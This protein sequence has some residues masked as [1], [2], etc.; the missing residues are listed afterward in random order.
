M[1][2]RRFLSTL[3]GITAAGF[4]LGFGGSWLR[5]PQAAVDRVPTDLCLSPFSRDALKL[6]QAA[7]LPSELTIAGS[8]LL[9]DGFLDLLAED[10]H[11]E[12]GQR[13]TVLGGGCDDGYMAAASGR[14]HLGNLCCPVEGSPAEKLH[15]ITVARD[16]KVVL[17]APDN[18]VED[19]RYDDLKRAFRGQITQWSELGGE[20]RPIALIVHEHCEKTYFEPVKHLILKPGEGWSAQALY[21]KTDQDQLRQL[22]RFR[23]C[24]GIASW[25]LAK[26][27]VERGALKAL[28]VNGVPPS[29]AAASSGDYPIVGPFNMIYS[30]WN[31]AVMRPFFDHLFGA[32]GR[33]LLERTV[34]PLDR[35]QAVALSRAPELGIA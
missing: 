3:T 7:P 26:P 8:R 16:V 13:I 24:L 30:Q 5:A 21:A 18:P 19:I 11:R 23:S 27:F 15:W 25:V 34:V 12:T 2:R 14:A 20:T 31:D 35:S 9:K 32:N 10:L 28:R 4:G 6:A 33:R 17:T 29:V 1:N 22:L